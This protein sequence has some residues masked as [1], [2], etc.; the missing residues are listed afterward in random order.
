MRKIKI[1]RSLSHSALIGA[2]LNRY[3]S[4]RGVTEIGGTRRLF[5]RTAARFRTPAT[6]AGAKVNESSRT[7]NA[8]SVRGTDAS[9]L[10][11]ASA[12]Y[13]RSQNCYRGLPY[14]S[15]PSGV[16]QRVFRA[17]SRRPRRILRGESRIT[18]RVGNSRSTSIRPTLSVSVEIT[19]RRDSRALKA[20]ER[21]EHL[22]LGKLR[23][24]TREFPK[25]PTDRESKSIEL[26]SIEKLLALFLHAIKSVGIKC[27]VDRPLLEEARE[28]GGSEDH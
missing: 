13:S 3:R 5:S 16:N 12:A 20:N 15:S 9:A 25:S 19:A 22:P 11:R 26:L 14:G 28:I 1:S 18:H 23:S 21:R 4:R 2:S 8:Y 6:S 7:G 24:A 27:G 17:D 10:A